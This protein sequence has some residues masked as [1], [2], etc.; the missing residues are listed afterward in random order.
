[1]AKYR[2]WAGGVKGPVSTILVL[3]FQYITILFSAKPGSSG[4]LPSGL[5]LSEILSDR[6]SS[7]LQEEITRR[8][9]KSIVS[10]GNR[11]NRFMINVLMKSKTILHDLVLKSFATDYVVA[12][13]ER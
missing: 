5:E 8:D 11:L 7:F 4:F 13:T 9:D 2:D 10:N 12:E 6:T 3:S 1:M